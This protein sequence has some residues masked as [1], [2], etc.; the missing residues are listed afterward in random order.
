MNKIPTDFFCLLS[1]RQI[2]SPHYKSDVVRKLIRE[3][4]LSLKK[5]DKAANG[6]FQL[7]FNTE[8]R[9]IQ[10]FC[11]IQQVEHIT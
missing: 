5:S 2:V 4:A 10:D 3:K 7:R 6:G 1:L 11:F 8:D 9:Y